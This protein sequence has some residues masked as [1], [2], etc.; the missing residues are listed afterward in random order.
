MESNK[1]QL[2]SFTFKIGTIVKSG[3]TWKIQKSDGKANRYIEQINENITLEMVA[4]PGGKFMRGSPAEELGHFFDESPQHLVKVPDFYLGRY[5]VTQAQWKA[6]A[7]TAIIE[8]ELD[9]D[10]SEFKGDNLPVEN[11]SWEQAQ[12]FCNRLSR[13]TR[14]SYRLPSEAEWEYACRAGTTTPFYFGETITGKLANY[15]SEQTYQKEV[16]VKQRSQT[17]PVG[18]FPANAWGLCDMHGNVW[19]WCEDRWHHNY[20]GAPKDGS[21]W[22]TGALSTSRVIRGGSWINIPRNCRSA[23]RNFSDTMDRDANLGLRLAVGASGLF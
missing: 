16:K 1:T 11:I 23:Y 2:E 5:P 6:I 21:A 22:L 7:S 19:E 8:Q 12:E 3:R 14:R 10:P 18:I 9:P 15:C 17:S 13:E 4:I 20:N